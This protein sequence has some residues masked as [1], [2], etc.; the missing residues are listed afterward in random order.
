VLHDRL[1]AAAART[2]DAIAV[3]DGER[4]ITYADLHALAARVA[5]LLL[6]L[7]TVRGDR[8]GLHL[9]KSVEAVAGAYGIM[10][11]GAAYVPL[12][13]GAPLARV[14]YI[15]ADCGLTVLLS[16]VEKAD[17]WPAFAAEDN[18]LE[19]VVVLNGEADAVDG[20][21]VHTR[22]DVDRRPATAPAPAVISLD[23]A[24]V[25]YTSG[26]TG[27]PKG[28]MLTHDNCLTFVDWA[29]AELAIAPA[30]RLSSHAPLHFDLSTFDL[31]AAVTA[32]ATLV[33][34]PA[35]ASVFPIKLARWIEA[36]GITVWY[37]VPSILSML[38]LRG[39][40]EPGSLPALRTVL[41]AGEVFPTK[42]LRLLMGQ[43]PEA[44]FVNLYGPTETN[45]CTWYD[46]ATPIAPDD[47][48]PIPIGR[49]I[50]DVDV[51]AV[52]DDG[53]TAGTGA[54]GE[55]WVRGRTVMKGYWN[56]AERTNRALTRHGRGSVPDL[57]YRT[58]DLV[59]PLP[60]GTLRFLG[61]RDSQ[62]KSRGYRIEL[63]DIEAALYAHD[64]V[65]ECAVLA[66]PDDLVTNRLH[67][68]VASNVAVTA[69]DLAA[70]CGGRL[71]RYMVPDTIEVVDV[72]PKT[73]TGKI[74]RQAMLRTRASPEDQ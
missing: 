62:V 36:N 14:A 35:Q 31:Y 23:L 73:S 18:D 26:S 59:E 29:V 46:V 70:F 68:V 60:D 38:A 24:Y 17:A 13:P 57:A 28:V 37:S 27:E 63:G 30:D 61:R 64:A 32:G 51:F 6:D 72:L 48:E 11:A 44:R 56:D 7:G 50:A 54:V 21:Q 66:I 42:Y 4:E 10:R 69:A 45:V 12:D 20:V 15:I 9:D 49:A 40:L 55:L 41:F 71:P 65:D 52:D 16:G 19:H 74:D 33:L 58:G 8:V 34:V 67:A 5:D 43:L 39:K 1:A 22:S 47:D 25:L 53:A 2:P 3:V